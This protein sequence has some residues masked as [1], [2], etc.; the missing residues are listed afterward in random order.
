MLAWPLGRS[1]KLYGTYT[2]SSVPVKVKN[3]PACSQISGGGMGTYAKDT[4]NS[5]WR[6]GWSYFPV[7][8]MVPSN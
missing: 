5:L 6:W 1:R 8:E 3:M 2:D 7:A 4:N